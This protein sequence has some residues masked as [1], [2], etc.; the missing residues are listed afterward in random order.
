MNSELAIT[1]VCGAEIGRAVD[2]F[3]QTG[4]RS[5]AICGDRAGGAVVDGLLEQ[6]AHCDLP[7]PEVTTYKVGAQ[8]AQGH[9]GL[10]LALGDTAKLSP[11]LAGLAHLPD[12]F[13]WAPKTA[14]YFKSRPVFVQSVP[15]AG[16]HVVFECLK[17]FGYAQPFSLDLPEF[18]GPFRDGTFYNL[19]H[20]P[21]QCL[22]VE[23]RTFPRFIEAISRSV[24]IF[25]LRDPRDV[26]VSLAYY[27][28]AH[29]NFHITTALFRGMPV[30][31]RISRVLSGDYPVPIHLNRHLNFDGTISDLF[32]LFLP[33]WR[34]SLPNVWRLR[35]E[36]L[37]GERGGRSAER[38]LQTIW[39]LQLALHVPGRPQE[40]CDRI[41]SQNALTFRRGQI[42]DHL[43]EFTKEHHL[44]F[45]QLAG[46]LLATTGYADQSPPFSVNVGFVG[47]IRLVA[48]GSPTAPILRDENFQGYNLVQYGGQFFAVP[49]A[50]G[51][52]DLTKDDSVLDGCLRAASLDVLRAIITS[53]SLTNNGKKSD[54]IAALECRIKALEN[55]LSE[56]RNY[57]PIWRRLLHLLLGADK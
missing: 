21:M 11:A 3:K 33:W 32:A 34:N 55:T 37:I 7:A 47:E 19:Q 26:A 22:S 20:M 27:L 45:E 36:D 44:T 24:V 6:F 48:D 28:A 18:V 2:R 42:G 51:E 29:P 46:G 30:S 17:A 23:Y 49:N 43:L 1:S 56:K 25:I 31:E 54:D 14:H 9:D 12:L 15:K 40:Y 35:Y 53:K 16:T 10:F 50:L 13:V 8:I 57:Q 52:M 41:F 38:Q 5:A 39:G 4:R